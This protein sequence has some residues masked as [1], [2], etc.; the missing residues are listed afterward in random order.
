MQKTAD[1][2]EDLERRLNNWMSLI[3]SKISQV[4]NDSSE[5]GSDRNSQILSKLDESQTTMAKHFDKLETNMK[6]MNH[7]IKNEANQLKEKIDH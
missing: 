5:S 3:E 6:D 2:L 1:T 7:K 4:N